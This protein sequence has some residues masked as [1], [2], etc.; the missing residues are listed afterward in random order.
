MLRMW[1]EPDKPG[2]IFAQ[3]STYDRHFVAT[4]LNLRDPI[5]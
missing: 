4:F 1:R 2:G 5:L 3:K